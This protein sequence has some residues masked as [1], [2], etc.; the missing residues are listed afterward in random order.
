MCLRGYLK[1]KVDVR[2]SALCFNRASILSMSASVDRVVQ[3]SGTTIRFLASVKPV[4]ARQLE[5][6]VIPGGGVRETR[7]FKGGA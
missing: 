7:T 1:T 5:E 3:L 4:C 2:V 6:K